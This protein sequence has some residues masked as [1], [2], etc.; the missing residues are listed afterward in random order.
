MTRAILHGFSDWL[1]PNCTSLQSRAPTVGSLCG[2]DIVLTSAYTEQCRSLSW[3]QLCLGRV[4]KKWAMAVNLYVKQDNRTFD[5]DYW[6]SMLITI[7]WRFTKRMWT[8]RNQI[9]HGSTV[10]EQAEVILTQLKNK[11]QT[12]YASF[13][14]DNNFVLPRHQYLF[15]HRTEEQRL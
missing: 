11:V 14:A 12:Y 5:Q 2:S 8:N 15:T 4:S 10:E 3:F 6:S 1:N 13:Q 7:L 9:V